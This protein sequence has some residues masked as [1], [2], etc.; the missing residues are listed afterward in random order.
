MPTKES[1]ES[2]PFVCPHCEQASN[3]VVRGRAYWQSENGSG[4]PPAE[5]SLVQCDRCHEPTLQVREDFGLGFVEDTPA[6]VY[7]VPQRFSRS[8]PEG[9]RREWEEA[10]TCFRAKAYSACAVMV[11]RTLEGTCAD[12]GVTGKPLAQSLKKLAVD[13]QIDETLAQWANALRLI[14]NKGAHYTGKPVAREDAEDALAFA[15]ALLD[16]IYVLRQ[17][18][19]QFLARIE[20]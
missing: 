18:F 8:V 12:Q 14:G 9:L 20:K 17:R 2:W 4:G 1:P 5:W 6:T 10:Q 13:G 19:A 11:R 7:P 3:G 15:E 16:H